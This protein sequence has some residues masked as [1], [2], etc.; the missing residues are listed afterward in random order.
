MGVVAGNHLP[1]E[2]GAPPVLLPQLPDQV[3]MVSGG[4]ACLP[5]DAD[6]C[7]PHSQMPGVWILVGEMAVIVWVFLCVR[8]LLFLPF[9]GRPAALLPGILLS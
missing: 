5:A 8:A 3:K 9:R 4:Q 6:R 7:Q 2:A 1:A